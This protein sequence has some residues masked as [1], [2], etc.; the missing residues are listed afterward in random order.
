[1]I[2]ASTVLRGP[3]GVSGG[4]QSM[5]RNGE[6][7]WSDSREH[8]LQLGHRAEIYKAI[9]NECKCPQLPGTDTAGNEDG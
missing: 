4:G 9:H 2:A 1:M 5:A 3:L 7:G 6:G 8:Y